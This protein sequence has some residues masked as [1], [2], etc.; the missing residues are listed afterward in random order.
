M[1]LQLYRRLANV[2]QETDL[3]QM[4]EEFNDRFGGMPEPVK[5]LIYQI[6]IKLKAQSAGLSSVTAEGDQIVLRYPALPEGVSSRSLPGLG[7][8]IRAGKNAY[9]MAIVDEDWQSVLLSVLDDLEKL[10]AIM[11]I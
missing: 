1:R 8:H 2:S 11:T 3:A 9:W 10:S 6:R 5:N 7:L 4:E